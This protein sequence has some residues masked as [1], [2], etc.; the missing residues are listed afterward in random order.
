MSLI[1]NGIDFDKR[2]DDEKRLL[3]MN[4]KWK[5][6]VE[7]GCGP[8]YEIE[9]VEPTLPQA[10]LEIQWLIDHLINACGVPRD[11]EIIKHQQKKAEEILAYSP[12]Q[13]KFRLHVLRS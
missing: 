11:H 1:I 4:L 8:Y 9:P 10:F 13:I 3:D 2:I 6:Q 12:P 7:Y 5:F